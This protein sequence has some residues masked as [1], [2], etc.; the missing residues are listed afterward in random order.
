MTRDPNP[1]AID[2]V[3]DTAL[4][5]ASTIDRCEVEGTSAV[6]APK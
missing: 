6:A 3:K 1:M 5:R 2:V 4:P